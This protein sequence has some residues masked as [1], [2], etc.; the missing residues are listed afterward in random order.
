MAIGWHLDGRVSAVVGTHT[1]VQTADERVLPRG[2]AFL[3][4]AGMTGGFD[5]VIGM[6]RDAALR[7]FLTLLPERLTPGRR[8]PAAQRRAGRASIPRPAARSRSSGCRSRTRPRRP[9]ARRRRAPAARRRAGGRGA[10]AARAEVAA[11]ARTAASSRRWRWSRSARTRPRRSTSSARR[12]RAPR[13]ASRCGASRSP[14]GTDTAR[15]GRARARAR[16][17]SATCTASWCSCRSRRPP[18]R[19]RC[20]RRSRPSKDVDGFHPGQRRT[21]RRRPAGLR[22]LHAAR[23]PRAAALLTRSRSPA[24]T[25][26]CSAAATSSAARSRRCC[27][28]RAST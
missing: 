4:D 3:C 23:H 2:T 18:R 8:R 28:A 14:A 12:R 17:R 26:W 24:A 19:R 22:A 25:P 10:L 11:A 13:S 5:S 16:R 6:D 21:A 15:R 9:S 1:H 7:R 20:S 27:R